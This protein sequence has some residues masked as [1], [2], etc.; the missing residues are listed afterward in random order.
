MLVRFWMAKSPVVATEEMN[1]EE[2][3]ALMQ[4]YK[5]RRLPIVRGENELQGIL[6]LSDLYPYMRPHSFNKARF[7]EEASEKL[8]NIPVATVMT[9]SPITCNRNAT[10]EEIGDT[11]RRERIGAI[12]VVEGRKLVR[13]ITEYD[14]LGAFAKIARA[15][16]DSRRICFRIPDKDKLNIFYTIVTL[17]E[18]N[19]LEILT[20]LTHVLP[21]E[22]SHL[23]ML[24]VRGQ[25][26]PEFIDT[27]W[28]NHY[29]VLMTSLLP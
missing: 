10:I 4:R 12:P 14:V 29:E 20:L 24:R 28:R 2:A 1:L 18:K 3:L 9:P 27:L 19:E 13:I 22:S 21:E 25:K 8:R 5:V 16:S 7:P 23:V 11:M 17:C 15:G 6:A 26:V